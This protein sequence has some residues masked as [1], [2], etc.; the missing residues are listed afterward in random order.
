[1]M[2]VILSGSVLVCGSLVSSGQQVEV[3]D[4]K[5]QQGP[6]RGVEEDEGGGQDRRGLRGKRHTERD[7]ESK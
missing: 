3:A 5:V 7:N 4:G 6:A 2:R 1:M